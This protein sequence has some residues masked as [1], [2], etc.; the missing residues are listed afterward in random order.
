MKIIRNPIFLGITLIFLVWLFNQ[1]YY[2][3]LQER[4]DNALQE[5]ERL[6]EQNKIDS[7][8]I[9]SLENIYYEL[10]DTVEYE[11]IDNTVITWPWGREEIYYFK[12]KEQV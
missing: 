1:L 3:Q 9:D 10:I 5:H 11:S 6:L 8:L 4:Y 7:L 12:Y 2:N